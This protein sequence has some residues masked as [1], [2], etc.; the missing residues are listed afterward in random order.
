MRMPD[1]QWAKVLQLRAI[2]E[3]RHVEPNVAEG[4]R[5]LS[6]QSWYQ[7][8]QELGSLCEERAKAPGYIKKAKSFMG[9][10]PSRVGRGRKL[11]E[12]SS[13]VIEI[14]NSSSRLVKGPSPGFKGDK[15]AL[16]GR[17]ILAWAMRIRVSAFI[18]ELRAGVFEDLEV[19]AKRYP[20]IFTK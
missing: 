4:S 14:R 8:A 10:Q 13:L 9:K 1:A 7:I 3:A 5:G 11:N 20:G 15:S 16:M 12:G 2:L 17:K 18:R 6:A 19:R